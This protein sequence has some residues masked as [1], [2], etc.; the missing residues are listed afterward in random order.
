M[1]GMA[2]GMMGGGVGIGRSRAIVKHKLVRYFDFDAEPGKK[3]RYRLRVAL[4]DP[5]NPESATR[6][7]PRILEPEVTDRISQAAAQRGEREKHWRDYF[8]R[9]KVARVDDKMI[10]SL[11]KTD[12]SQRLTDWSEPTAPVS[13]SANELVFAGAA[14]P[15]DTRILKLENNREVRFTLSEP[16]GKMVPVVW[17]SEKAV[18]VPAESDVTLGSVLN[19]Q[20]DCRVPH[21]LELAIKLIEGYNLVTNSL[22]VDI[23]GGEPL[24]ETRD[25][26]TAPGEFAVID[27]DGRLIVQYELDQIEEYRRFTYAEDEKPETKTREGAAAD[28]EGGMPGMQ[29]MP[30]GGMPGG[31]GPMGPMGPM[32]GGKK[33]KK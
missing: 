32:G 7:E 26:L 31:M 1:G 20:T 11:V 19:L 17:D 6:P 18:H 13:L 9:R 22:V 25:A 28:P 24:D 33:G 16:A 23:R 15:A 2:G 14:V 5:N 12:L 29:G 27:K 8:V 30:G 21:P 3:Y 4:D 10:E